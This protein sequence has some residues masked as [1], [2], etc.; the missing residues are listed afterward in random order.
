MPYRVGKRETCFGGLGWVLLSKVRNN[1]LIVKSK[2]CWG[3]MPLRVRKG[4]HSL[5]GQ[6]RLG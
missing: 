5:G 3:N 2:V 6:V 4:K 1:A